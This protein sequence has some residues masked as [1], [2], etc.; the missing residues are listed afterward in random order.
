MMAPAARLEFRRRPAVAA[1]LL[2]ALWPSPGLRAGAEFPPLSA[3]WRGARFAAADIGELQAL[4][5]L[6]PGP[7]LQLLAPQVLAF[8]LLMAILTAPRFPLPIW[9]AL[10]VRNDLRLLRPWGEDESFDLRTRVGA[11]RVLAKGAEVDLHTSV[12]AGSTR[13]WEGCTTFYFR[14]RFGDAGT[15]DGDAQPPA[16]PE[17]QLARWQAP[18]GERYAFCRLS[19]DFN[20]IHGFDRYARWFGFRGAFLHPQRVLGQCL[21]RIDGSQAPQQRLRSWLRGPVC[22]GDAVTLLAE[23]RDDTTTFALLAHGDPRA[24]MIGQW[25]A[26]ASAPATL[27]EGDAGG[28]HAP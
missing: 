3:H 19:G 11:T 1:Y 28:D 26:A 21:A 15:A 6:G 18:T 2:R 17:R 10:Q 13:Y 14:G 8:P 9:N 4:T 20:G 27:A 24:A 22:Y 23:T 7:T 16:V 5:G 12:E 25:Q